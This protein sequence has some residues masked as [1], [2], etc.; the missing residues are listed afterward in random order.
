MIVDINRFR[1]LS[2]K[3][4]ALLVVAGLLASTVLSVVLPNRALAAPALMERELQTTSAVPSDTGVTLT[5][6][7][8]TT[9]ATANID[10][11][12]IEFC[13]SPL[14]SCTN[15]NG[16]SNA[17]SDY[18]PVLPASPTATL[19]NFTSGGNTAS[20]VDGRQAVTG[21]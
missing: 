4:Q 14:S 11:I 5:W 18:I 17:G 19:T 7:F 15:V 10:H 6:I 9:S 20:R 2:R 3:L 8:D 1:D 16:A 21:L 12:E 13:D